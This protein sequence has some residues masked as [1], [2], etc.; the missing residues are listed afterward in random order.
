MQADFITTGCHCN[1]EYWKTHRLDCEVFYSASFWWLMLAQSKY[2]VLQDLRQSFLEG[3]IIWT[4]GNDERTNH[5]TSSY[6]R[7]FCTFQCVCLFW[8][9]EMGCWFT[10]I[11]CLLKYIHCPGPMN[12]S[13]GWAS[14]KVDHQKKAGFLLHRSLCNAWR[15]HKYFLSSMEMLPLPVD[16]STPSTWYSYFPPTL[17]AVSPW[18]VGTMF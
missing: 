12:K 4:G 13:L 17:L 6:H 15:Q 2:L 16:C 5:L 1:W 11:V 7:A 14:E 18:L 3:S 8:P 10:Q 9:S